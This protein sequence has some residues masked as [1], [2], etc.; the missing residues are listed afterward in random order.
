[1]PNSK[2]AE[3]RVRQNEKRRLENKA[4]RTSMKT[5]V[6]KVMQAP[7]TA[8][9]EAALPEAMKRVDKAAKK[10]VIHANTAARTKSRLAKAASRKG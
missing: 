3:K 8:A 5:A 6:K 9:A 2:Q 10:R 7:D 1:M 4:V